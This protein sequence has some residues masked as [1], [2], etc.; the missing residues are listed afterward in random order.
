MG[1]VGESMTTLEKEIDRLQIEINTLKRMTE[2]YKNPK[3]LL[4]TIK[5]NEQ[6]LEWFKELNSYRKGEV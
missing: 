1:R 3:E 6:Y 5:Q 4:K 2:Q